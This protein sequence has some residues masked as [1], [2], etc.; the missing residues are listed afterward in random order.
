MA[1]TLVQD[2]AASG[3]SHDPVEG[4]KR[5]WVG[6]ITFD[7]SYAAGGE[8]I[9]AAEFGFRNIF[10]FEVIGH[11]GAVADKGRSLQWDSAAGTLELVGSIAGSP[12]GV[13][14]TTATDESATVFTVRV[15]GD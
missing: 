9:T 3:T 12:A 1:L 2:R 4:S 11:Q 6:T 14:V 8:L 10:G 5:T 7:S 13:V 15:K